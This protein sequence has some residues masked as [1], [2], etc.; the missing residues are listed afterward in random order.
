MGKLGAVDEQ[1]TNIAKRDFPNKEDKKTLLTQAES[2]STAKE[3]MKN[4]PVNQNINSDTE[5]GTEDVA[6]ATDDGSV[7][8]DGSH[9]DAD[10]ED[11]DS[12]D[13]GDGP[14]RGEQD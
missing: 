13:G 14:E 5:V 8:N 6:T 1:Q 3:W 10:S 4:N 2:K 12:D 11:P 9:V 7:A